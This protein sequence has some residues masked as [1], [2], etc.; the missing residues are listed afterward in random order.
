[1]LTEAAAS[2]D[3]EAVLPAACCSGVGALDVSV[4]CKRYGPGLNIKQNR[5]VGVACVVVVVVAWVRVCVCVCDFWHK[6]A[7]KTGQ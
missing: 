6:Q 4:S 2:S 3:D 5:Y 7:M 1:M